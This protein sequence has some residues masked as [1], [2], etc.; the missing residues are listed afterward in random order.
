MK[1]EQILCVVKRPELEWYADTTRVRSELERKVKVDPDWEERM[2]RSM[3]NQR[4]FNKDFKAYA[5]ELRLPIRYVKEHEL[6]PSTEK[7]DL[8]IALGGDGTM[9]KVISAYPDVPVLG[10]NNDY[11]AVRGEGSVGATLVLDTRNYKEGLQDVVKGHYE[12][13]HWRMLCARIDGVRVG[14]ASGAYT[15]TNEIIIRNPSGGTT[16]GTLLIGNERHVFNGSSGPLFCTG[17]G[18][19]AHHR[20]A[21][22]SV[23]SRDA[24]LIGYLVRENNEDCN[25]RVAGIV[26]EGT[27]IEFLPERGGYG[28]FF[29][30]KKVH[31]MNLYETLSVS[32]CQQQ[33]TQAVIPRRAKDGM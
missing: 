4:M 27:T 32:L 10:V 21:G 11:S 29:D 15:A 18:S 17:V 22:G 5:Q 2:I 6:T 19:T 13:Q 26:M 33:F 12:I 14:D 28:V 9:V 3:I 31:T 16:G 1:L 8:V 30:A 20:N 7:P 24:P 25:P 23:F